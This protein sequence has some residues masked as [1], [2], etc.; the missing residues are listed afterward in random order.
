MCAVFFFFLWSP[1]WGCLWVCLPFGIAHC[2]LTDSSSLKSRVCNQLHSAFV[3][4]MCLPY[5]Y[6]SGPLYFCLVI[7]VLLGPRMIWNA[8][9]SRPDL[10]FTSHLNDAAL[11]SLPHEYLVQISN[12][13]RGSNWEPS[14]L[15]CATSPRNFV[16]L[17]FSS[18]TWLMTSWP[19]CFTLKC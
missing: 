6:V 17:S 16:R 13:S 11:I 1:F 5:L 18:L 7:Q 3:G 10:V 4:F 8:C 2:T 15:Y 9:A 12:P 14:R 19:P